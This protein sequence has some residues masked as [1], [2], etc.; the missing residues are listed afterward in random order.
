[1]VLPKGLF[2]R[3]V[4]SLFSDGA[5]DIWATT[6]GSG[7]F[8]YH[9]SSGRFSRSSIPGLPATVINLFKVQRMLNGE[10]WLFTG[11]WHLCAARRTLDAVAVTS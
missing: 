4:T 5:H 6:W 10:L 8:V 9:P 11:R 3:N 1:M 2:N 7:L